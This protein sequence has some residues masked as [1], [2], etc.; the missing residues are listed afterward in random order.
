MSA[1]CE[2]RTLFLREI[3]SQIFVIAI[4]SR[5][6]QNGLIL[7]RNAHRRHTQF[8][9]RIVQDHF[10]FNTAVLF[11]YMHTHLCLC[12]LRVQPKLIF[13]HFLISRCLN[14]KLFVKL[15]SYS[16]LGNQMCQGEFPKAQIILDYM[17]VCNP[18]ETGVIAQ[19]K[20]LPSTE[21]HLVRI[22]TERS[23]P[24][25]FFT[26]TE[27]LRQFRIISEGDHQTVISSQSYSKRPLLCRIPITTSYYYYYFAS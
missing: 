5:A 16:Q 12:Q 2:T 17:Y 3:I 23:N 4:W 19:H 9:V 15:T 6:E 13:R 8:K 14:S 20:P 7:E 22:Q 24:V 1:P 27:V 26:S 10:V 11:R 25:H 21:T 18:G